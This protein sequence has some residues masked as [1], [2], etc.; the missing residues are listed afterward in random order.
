MDK[1]YDSMDADARLRPRSISPVYMARSQGRLPM[2]EQETAAGGLHALNY[3]TDLGP[4]TEA[5]ASTRNRQTV[6]MRTTTG[7]K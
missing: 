3:W 4:R 7:R 2:A 5:L 1:V 6:H